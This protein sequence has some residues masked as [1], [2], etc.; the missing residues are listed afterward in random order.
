MVV[1]DA[2]RLLG[3]GLALGIPLALLAGRATGSASFLFGLSAYDP[4]T[5]VAAC[6]LLA[7]SG[8]AASVIPARQA[9]RLSALAALRHD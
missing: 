5:L 4:A 7:A 9:S 3:I 6:T 2:G 1:A 8:V